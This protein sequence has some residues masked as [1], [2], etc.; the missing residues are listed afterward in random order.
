MESM[1]T[2]RNGPG[3]DDAGTLEGVEEVAVRETATAAGDVEL[4]RARDELAA[5][6][7]RHLRLAAEFDNYR[8]RTERERADTWSRSQADLTSGLLDALDDLGRV[9]HV[10][11]ESTSVGALL[12]G[13]QLV[14]RKLQ[15]VLAAAGLEEIDAQDKR[16][17]PA[18][19]EALVMV[20]A[21][22]P[23]QDDTVAGVLQKGY[24]F[25]GQLLRPA[26]V[27]VRKYHG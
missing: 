20:D 19:M 18:T 17:D 14:E 16:F 27:Q 3:D 2:T 25:K 8:R 23:E 6:N 7:D 15:R 12:D 13:V 21:D 5:L 22:S 11:A 24:R 9:A 1:D 4:E 10:D 26:R